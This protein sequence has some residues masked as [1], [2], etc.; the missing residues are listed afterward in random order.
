MTTTSRPAPRSFTGENLL[1]IAMPMGGIGTGCICLSGYGALQDFA[2]HNR[3]AVTA[4]PGNAPNEAAFALLR[5]KGETPVTKLVQGQ[6]PRGKVYDQG[7][8]GE[9]YYKGGYEGLP[10]FD[11]CSFTN[12]FPFGH[13]ELAHPRVPLKVKVAG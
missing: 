4:V 12:E 13:V 9:G 2:I 5:I 6:L 7:L 1:Q 8:Q 11:S 10:R 3:P